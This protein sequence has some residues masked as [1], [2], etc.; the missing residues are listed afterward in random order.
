MRPK[1]ENF[2]FLRD[3]QHRIMNSARR[4][5]QGLMTGSN[6]QFNKKLSKANL[7]FEIF[8]FACYKKR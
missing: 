5:P 3:C 8:R 7:L 1:F 4:E 2:D 6:D